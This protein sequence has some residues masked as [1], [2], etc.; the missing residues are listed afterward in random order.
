[1]VEDSEIENK[2]I[3]KMSP[4]LSR[5]LTSYLLVSLLSEISEIQYVVLRNLLIILEKRPDFLKSE[6]RV[7]FC[8][9]NDPL[10]V[11]LEKIDVLVK[12]AD[13]ENFD[14][15]LMEFRELIICLFPRYVNEVELE[16]VK[17]AIKAISRTALK[18]PEMANR[19]VEVLIDLFS[20]K[21]EYVVQEAIIGLTVMIY[22]ITF[23]MF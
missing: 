20:N 14:Q 7:F 18:L 8:K 2:I 21:V 10:Y 12:L 1:M 11:K 23:R 5:Y 15:L 4:S 3:I 6:I 16:F 13:E 9:F 19:C 22:M 17:K